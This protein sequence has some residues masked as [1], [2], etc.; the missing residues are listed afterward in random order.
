VAHFL[1]DPNVLFALLA[2]G[3]LGLY[4]EFNHP[5]LIVPGTLG[6]VSLIAAAIGLSLIPFNVGGLV[7]VLLGFGMFAL[8]VWVGGKGLF[9]AGG[10][11][12]LV[13]GGLLLFEVEGFDLTVAPL[14]LA[15]VGGASVLVAVGI[16]FAVT[17]AQ[18][19]RVV[20]GAEGLLGAPCRVTIGGQG[21]G[22]VQLA[23]EDW[24]ATWNGVMEAGASVRVVRVDGLLVVVEPLAPS[25]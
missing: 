2:L 3:A 12:G 24:R 17:R 15:M 4:V 21:S 14:N 8:E 22:R 16:G 7:L 18:R 10:V 6:A 20:T 25:S 9:A 13:L 5:G 23:G 11:A 19:A 1:G